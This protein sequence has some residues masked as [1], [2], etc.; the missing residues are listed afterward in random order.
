[1]GRGPRGVDQRHAQLREAAPLAVGVPD[2][3]VA[4]GAPGPCVQAD[5]R[6]VH[7]ARRRR[8]PTIKRGLTLTKGWNKPMDFDLTPEQEDMVR[9]AREAGAEWRD[10]AE[11][12][13]ISNRAPIDEVT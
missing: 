11:E 1:R 8:V 2:A 9:R 10:H 4:G 12:W 6:R 5:R 3:G 13:D 7:P